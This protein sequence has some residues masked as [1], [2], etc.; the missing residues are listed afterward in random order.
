M[1]K[2]T[3]F[4][5]MF[6]ACC[7]TSS[8]CFYLSSYVYPPRLFMSLDRWTVKVA[9]E[10]VHLHVISGE[11]TRM[12]TVRAKWGGVVMYWQYRWH[13]TADTSRKRV[14][15]HWLLF[16]PLP[17][18]HPLED[19]ILPIYLPTLMSLVSSASCLNRPG[20]IWYDLVLVFILAIDL[21]SYCF[22]FFFI[23]LFLH[24]SIFPPK[25]CLSFVWR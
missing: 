7:L 3:Y 20:V 15:T 5:Y 12:S 2:S 25:L 14:C 6:L 10:L 4:L 22:I 17:T 23:L 24:S 9:Q 8:I 21:F 13:P 19:L 16:V 18:S 1:R 11:Q